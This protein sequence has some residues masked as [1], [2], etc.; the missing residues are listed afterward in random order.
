MKKK[1]R[2]IEYI[3]IK[4]IFI[5]LYNLSCEYAEKYIEMLEFNKKN[6]KS[7]NIGEF[8]LFHYIINDYL[9]IND[10]FQFLNTDFKKSLNDF[11]NEQG[12]TNFSL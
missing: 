3:A 6:N 9:Y 5:S 2:K 12:I 1:N 10:N 8:V 4:T 11:I 7:E